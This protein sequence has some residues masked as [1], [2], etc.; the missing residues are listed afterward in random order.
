MI[1]ISDFKQLGI[2]LPNTN[3]A[4]DRVLTEATHKELETI[5]QGKD[6]KSIMNSILKQSA[7][8]PSSNKELLQ[9][10]KNNPTLKNLGDVTTTVKDLLNSLKSEKNPLPI[11]KVLQTFLSDVKDLKNTELKQKLENSGVVLESK[12]K[13]AKNPQVELKNTLIDLVK[14][15]QKTNSTPS[16]AIAN[17]AKILLN[18]EALK[19]VTLPDT[20]IK[21]TN[22]NPTTTS[23]TQV[24]QVDVPTS[25]IVTN[26]MKTN[27]NTEVLKS[28]LTSD[29]KTNPHDTQKQNLSSTHLESILNTKENPKVLKQLSSQVQTL[30]E[31]IQTKQQKADT[32]HSP[33][34]AKAIENLTHKI[35]P[36]LLTSENFK[37]PA[38]KEPLEQ[39]AT[40]V[41]KSF[42]MESKGI[43]NSLEKIFQALK[44]IEQTTTVPKTSLDIFTEKKIPQEIT[45]LI[46]NIKEVIQKADPIF[47]RDTTNILKKLESLNTPQQ[48]SPQ[49]N[50]K[51]ILSSDLK[52]VLL[53]TSEE[54]VKSNHPNQV[55]ISKQIDK[56]SLQIDNYQLLSHLS[57]G[58]SMYLP[59]S[60]DM[61]EEGNIQMK[62]SED[63]KFYVDIDLK[64]K[65]YGELNLKLT[66]YD[67][68]QLNI[69]IYSANQ[70]LKSLIRDN[71]PSLRS[72]LIN[73]QI[74]P[75][76]IRIH[77]P[78]TAV[79]ASPYQTQDDNIYMGFEIKA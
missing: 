59:F 21:Q 25:R 63:D 42:T 14:N 5:T 17:E 65:E 2:I 50:V 49:N 19:S 56:L 57:N 76:E 18:T 67:K 69:N 73:T 7:D 3:K 9:L 33:V 20:K 8:N 74:T 38:I 32:I 37:L 51:E 10:V 48:L 55:E 44:T 77:E 53:Q 29:I 1:N 39:I 11:E 4:L 70:E 30:I 13:N 79:S 71:I 62:K 58:T 60:W 15:L 23:N 72:A 34:I 61:M 66:L 43:L 26:E 64:L 16:R 45:K 40:Q 31:N 28:A 68:N 41:S 54:I 6:L 35:E 47:S 36:K 27:V 75:R 22:L 78:K 12:I 52:A 24:K 46:D